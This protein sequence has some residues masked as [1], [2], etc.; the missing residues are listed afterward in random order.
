MLI[1]LSLEMLRMIHTAVW[2]VC[3][4]LYSALECSLH[5]PADIE[6]ASKFYLDI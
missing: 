5:R 2:D 6:I 3:S 1:L 4:S